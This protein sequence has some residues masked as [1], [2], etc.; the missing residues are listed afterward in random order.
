M[1]A[2]L[3]LSFPFFVLTVLSCS[4]IRPLDVGSSPYLSV[5]CD[6]GYLV[7]KSLKISD[8]C[9]PTII[10]KLRCSIHF[11]TVETSDFLLTQS[12]FPAETRNK[13]NG[14]GWHQVAID[15]SNT[16]CTN[17][18][19]GSKKKAGAWSFDKLAPCC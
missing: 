17:G 16:P 11:A 4:M 15:T 14:V 5:S 2:L 3:F 8:E 10:G 6:Q 7:Q 13:C 19:I 12:Q 18:S 1:K 9:F